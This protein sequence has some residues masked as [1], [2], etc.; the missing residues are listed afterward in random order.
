MA[1][2]VTQDGEVPSIDPQIKFS[3]TA[4]GP[5]TLHQQEELIVTVSS[6]GPNAS[7]NLKLFRDGLK[8]PQNTE[9]LLQYDIRWSGINTGPTNASYNINQRWVRRFDAQFTFRRQITR[10]YEIYALESTS[11][12][13]IDDTYG[14]NDTIEITQGSPPAP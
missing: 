10:T 11:V 5:D 14:V 12:H 3:N 7:G 2:G 8:I 9:Q 4:L 13:L 6:F 1:V